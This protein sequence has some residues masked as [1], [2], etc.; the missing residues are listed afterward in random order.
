MAHQIALLNPAELARAVDPN[1]GEHLE[2][3]LDSLQAIN[4][5]AF[6]DVAEAIYDELAKRRIRYHHEP[7]SRDVHTQWIRETGEVL[8]GGVGATCVDLAVLFCGACL[9]YGLLPLLVVQK[10][11][12]IV[13]VSGRLGRHEWQEKFRRPEEPFSQHS[14]TLRDGGRLIYLLQRQRYR[15]IDCT[16]LAEESAR[17]QMTFS[18]ACEAAAN[19]LLTNT[20]EFDVALDIET[21]H[22]TG[23]EPSRA[24][25]HPY[26]PLRTAP[27]LVH[28]RWARFAA[29]HGGVLAEESLERRVDGPRPPLADRW[30]KFLG[31]RSWPTRLQERIG[32]LAQLGRGNEAIENLVQKLER[33]DLRQPYA[34]IGEQARRLRIQEC[35]G[36]TLRLLKKA[37]RQQRQPQEEEHL[38]LSEEAIQ[39]QLREL[40]ILEK[41]LDTPRYGRCFTVLGSSGSGKTHFV[42]S[43]LNGQLADKKVWVLPVTLGASS[44]EAG[45]QVLDAARAA[46]QVIWTDFDQLN[47]F[48]RNQN[49]RLVVA[50]DNVHALARDATPVW[51]RLV[52][53]VRMS[54]VFECI[55]W[56]F[57]CLDTRYDDVADQED[58]ILSYGPDS[59]D[60]G[61]VSPSRG[62]N[63]RGWLMLDELNEQHHVGLRVL[64]EFGGGRIHVEEDTIDPSARR[65]LCSPFAA[66]ILIDALKDE[67]KTVSVANLHYI[68]FMVRF[69][70]GRVKRTPALRHAKGVDAVRRI[71]AWLHLG[72]LERGCA[73]ETLMATTSDLLKQRKHRDGVIEAKDVEHVLHLLRDANLLSSA[74]NLDSNHGGLQKE[75]VEFRFESFWHWTIASAICESSMGQNDLPKRLESAV[76]QSA[77]RESAEAIVEMTLL[78]DEFRHEPADARSRQTSALWKPVFADTRMLTAAHWFA[79]S[80]ARPRTQRSLVDALSDH[81][82]PSMDSRSAFALLHFLANAVDVDRVKLLHLAKPHFKLFAEHKFGRFFLYVAERQLSDGTDPVCIARCMAAFVGAEDMAIEEPLA[83]ISMEALER[84]CT[85]PSE[86][87]SL[88]MKH[89]CIAQ[90]FRNVKELEPRPP[91]IDASTTDTTEGTIKRD[92]REW[93]FHLLCERLLERYDVEAFKW[94]DAAGWYALKGEKIASGVRALMHRQANFAFG[95]WYRAPSRH[96]KRAAYDQ[97]VDELS[98][99]SELNKRK[100][101]FFMVRHTVATYQQQEVLVD[102]RFRPILARLRADLELADFVR[103]WEAFFRFNLDN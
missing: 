16:G 74:Q 103:R 15:F 50:V 66:W 51:R 73:F 55:D 57:T 94:L 92:W 27:L 32:K 36:Q 9:T 48:L 63:E 98:R 4:S 60:E 52:D 6:L 39:R 102:K 41:F 80:K 1:A 81:G 58:F 65:Q 11:H 43:I 12:A 70:K 53:L 17:R 84:A 75:V 13:G 54:T 35:H 67:Q 38:G 93:V 82:P 42:A 22:R 37:R 86:M 90:D 77:R 87:V 28:K 72:M 89:V 23:F 83:R 45:S 8:Y 61:T 29:A 24:S 88:I 46:T 14:P 47:N 2:L 59:G 56:V 97:L 5:R 69:W 25:P 40:G 34:A 19:Q 95:F 31:A 101:A 79:A 68:D 20:P 62:G 7:F 3:E 91:R 100:T 30:H 18:Q 85:A 33:L 10:G 64:G 71:A 99:H 21:L 26:D 49:L 44:H 96:E 78:M 76:R